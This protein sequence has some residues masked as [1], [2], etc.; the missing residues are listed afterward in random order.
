[1]KPID[2]VARKLRVYEFTR[3]SGYTPL[4]KQALE[5]ALRIMRSDPLHAEDKIIERLWKLEEKQAA[6]EI[7]AFA[8][9][10]ARAVSINAL[11]WVVD[12]YDLDRD[13]PILLE[14]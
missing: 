10:P 8:T 13:E 4:I 12:E 14:K 11:K 7:M 1:M 6:P 5:W 9:R 3:G 2:E